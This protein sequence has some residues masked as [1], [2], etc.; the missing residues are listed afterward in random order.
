MRTKASFLRLVG[1]L[2]LLLIGN[3]QVQ[4]GDH[5]QEAEEEEDNNDFLY[6][7]DDAVPVEEYDYE[8]HGKQLDPQRPE[9]IFG[10][11]QGPRVVLF[12]APWVRLVLFWIL[13]E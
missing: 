13:T 7:T 5:L 6:D 9:F 3:F 12:Y 4:A 11:N 1:V 10:P 2:V 8:A